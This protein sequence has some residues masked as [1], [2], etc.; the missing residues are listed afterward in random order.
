MSESAEDGGAPVSEV[1][2][3]NEKPHSVFGSYQSVSSFLGS[4]RD[5]HQPDYSTE[6]R[7]ISLL[8]LSQ[9]TAIDKF[10]SLAM[11]NSQAAS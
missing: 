9:L 1:G 5:A 4:P 3:W 2:S 11:V 7:F 10:H 8:V 6:S